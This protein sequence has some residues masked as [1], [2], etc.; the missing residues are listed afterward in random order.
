M[1]MTRVR[2][3]EQLNSPESG[4]LSTSN[5]YDLLLEAGCPRD[6]AQQLANQRGWDR[7]QAG[8]TM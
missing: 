5:F 1:V 2:A 4:A 7:L 6:E 3:W 8:V